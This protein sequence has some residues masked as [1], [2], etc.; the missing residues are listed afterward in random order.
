MAVIVGKFPVHIEDVL[1]IKMPQDAKILCVQTQNHMPQMWAL[2]DTE[3]PIEARRFRLY[4][5]GHPIDIEEN[6]L[7]YIGTFQLLEGDLVY[8]LF[9]QTGPR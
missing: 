8:H 5:T 9:E 6:D 1:Y 7:S 2:I 3:K 4:A